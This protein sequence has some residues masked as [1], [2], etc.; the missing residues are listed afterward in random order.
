MF[1]L[2]LLATSGSRFF[3][4]LICNGKSDDEGDFILNAQVIALI[5]IKVFQQLHHEG[6]DEGLDEQ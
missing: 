5:D 6:S 2:I 3:G 4:N 1:Q